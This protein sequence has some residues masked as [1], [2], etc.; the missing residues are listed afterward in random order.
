MGGGAGTKRRVERFEQHAQMLPRNLNVWRNKVGRTSGQKVGGEMR[1]STGTTH[2]ELIAKH[3]HRAYLRPREH[4]CRQPVVDRS[5]PPQ[6]Q[7]RRIAMRC[8][9]RDRHLRITHRCPNLIPISARNLARVV[10]PDGIV[11]VQREVHARPREALRE[12]LGLGVCFG[13]F[14]PSTHLEDRDFHVP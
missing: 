5:A 7:A 2:D 12:H 14:G 13:D 3:V 4:V 8:E 6:D 10:R 1:R 11:G 9:M